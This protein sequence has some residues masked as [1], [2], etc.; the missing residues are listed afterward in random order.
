[1]S[2][3]VNK[4]LGVGTGP[5]GTAAAPEPPLPPPLPPPAAP[6]ADE[7]E[8][9]EEEEEG[10]VLP[11]SASTSCTRLWNARTFDCI[12]GEI[13]ESEIMGKINK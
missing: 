9:E 1:M 2:Q 3:R 13:G 4:A 8:E 11:A 7:E 6:P 5:E 10:P 12:T